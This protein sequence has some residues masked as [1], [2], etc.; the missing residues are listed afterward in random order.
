MTLCTAL[1]GI[2]LEPTVLIKLPAATSYAKR[3]LRC[4]ESRRGVKSTASRPCDSTFNHG[5][6]ERKASIIWIGPSPTLWTT[7]IAPSRL[8]ASMICSHAERAGAAVVDCGPAAPD[9]PAAVVGA[10]AG[11]IVGA[12]A[13]GVGCGAVWQAARRPAPMPRPARRR[14]WR[15][16]DI[17]AVAPFRPAPRGSC[18]VR[19]QLCPVE[20]RCAR[21]DQ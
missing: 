6:L 11:A 3:S 5:C 20:P 15:L 7:D 10:A 19:T 21:R 4:S 14:K 9:E 2:Q 13:C 18:R 8:A 1:A 16:E 12:T 17:M